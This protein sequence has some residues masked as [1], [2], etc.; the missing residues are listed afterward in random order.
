MKK[1]AK[2]LGIFTLAGIILSG[3]GEAEVNE[4]KEEKPKQEQAAEKKEEKAAKEFYSVGETVSIDGVEITLKSAKF[5]PPAEYSEPAN[6]KV[7]TIEIGAKN[8][9][10]MEALVD[11]TSFTIAGADGTQFEQYYGYDDASMFSHN[12]KKGNQVSDKVAFDVTEQDE[13]IVYYSP[14]FSLK[15]NA[16]IKFKITKAELQ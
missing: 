10:D 8:S 3:C 5:T 15:E 14:M 16:E 13:Y 6:G 7:I 9:S 2:S 12:L 1:I 4:V 11:N